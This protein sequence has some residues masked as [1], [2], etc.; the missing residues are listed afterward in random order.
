M[1]F[2]P[3]SAL[4]GVLRNVLRDNKMNP[5]TLARVSQAATA[6]RWAAHGLGVTLV[7]ASAVPHGHE[8]LTRPVFP[9][10]SQPVVAAIRPGAGPAETAL[11][12]F[13]RQESWSE[14]V[15]LSPVS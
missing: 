5:T 9:V 7:P 1:R 4:D 13:L 15:F 3:D 14:S 11:L 12:E 10:V 2:G 8:H 6:V